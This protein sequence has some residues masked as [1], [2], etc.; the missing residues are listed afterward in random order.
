MSA[1]RRTVSPRRDPPAERGFWAEALAI[2]VMAFAVLL[3]LSLSS[4][5]PDDPVPWPLGHW[6]GEPVDNVAGIVGAFLAELLRQI[7]GHASWAVPPLL[8]LLGWRMFWG[9]L[10]RTNSWM[11]RRPW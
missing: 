3:V 9:F 7:L 5:R 11:S 6:A 10:L 4:Y 1:R 8:I 2:V